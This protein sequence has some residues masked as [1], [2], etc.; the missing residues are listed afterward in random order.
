ML[1]NKNRKENQE[2]RKEKEKKRKREN[3]I[4]NRDNLQTSHLIGPLLY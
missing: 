2:T 1:I 3:G 4:A